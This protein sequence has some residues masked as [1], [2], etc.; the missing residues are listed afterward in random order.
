MVSIRQT[1]RKYRGRMA[2]TYEAKRVKQQRWHRENETVER[3]MA[4]A[5]GTVLDAPVG[6]GRYL[7]LWRRLGLTCAG[8]DVSDEML[9]QARAKMN[10]EDKV[11]LAIGDASNMSCFG[12]RAFDSAVCVRFLDLIDEPAMQKVVRELCRVVRSRIVLT[13]RLG[14]CYTPKVNTATHDEGQFLSLVRQ[15]GWRVAE[16][17]REGFILGWRVMQLARCQ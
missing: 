5:T 16:E 13:I 6:T 1:A 9:A 12:D 8:I 3:M 2:E 4:S 7:P 14:D 17:E 15:L 11:T 10:P